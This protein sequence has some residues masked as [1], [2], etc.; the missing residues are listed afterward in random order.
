M[1]T[2]DVVIIVL[3]I[4]STERLTTF[5][6]DTVKF[7]INL[8]S[9]LENMWNHNFASQEA[10]VKEFKQNSANTQERLKEIMNGI[11]TVY[12]QPVQI[13]QA[14]LDT[15]QALMQIGYIEKNI[16]ILETKLLE[17]NSNRNNLEKERPKIK[18]KEETSSRRI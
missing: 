1:I 8:A 4:F 7:E 3:N 16:K 11:K 12:K 6:K 17:D 9:Y 14:D 15:H 5:Y 10:L 13:R 2:Y 18:T